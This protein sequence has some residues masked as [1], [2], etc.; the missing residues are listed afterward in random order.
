MN[1]NLI[2]ISTK[3]WPVEQINLISTPAKDRHEII[4][5]LN[6]MLPKH[7]TSHRDSLEYKRKFRAGIRFHVGIRFHAGIS[8]KP[9][10]YNHPLNSFFHSQDI[11]ICQIQIISWNW[12]NYG[13]IECLTYISEHNFWNNSK[14]HF[15]LKH[16]NWQ[17]DRSLKNNF[18]NILQPKVRL[19]LV[20]GS[21]CFS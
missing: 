13:I 5:E 8:F 17:G 11:Q 3:K 20:S 2:F 7:V 6:F 18:E 19:E 14:N 12:N 21:F 10:T 15:G 4:P 9:L 1:C 16:Q